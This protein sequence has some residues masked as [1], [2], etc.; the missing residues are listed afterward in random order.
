MIF[1][2]FKCLSLSSN[3]NLGKISQTIPWKE[4]KM[5][6]CMVD[7]EKIILVVGYIAA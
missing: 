2:N 4:L 3:K 1:L 5:E 6:N 7:H